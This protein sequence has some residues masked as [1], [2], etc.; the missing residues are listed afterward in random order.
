[1]VVG[2]AVVEGDRERARR[3]RAAALERVDQLVER[4]DAVG[5]LDERH[6]EPERLDRQADV[7]RRVEHL[8]AAVG[9]GVVAQHEAAGPLP[10]EPREREQ[11]GVVQHALQQR[12]DG[13]TVGL[14][15]RPVSHTTL[16]S[17]R[18]SQASARSGARFTTQK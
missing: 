13:A 14:A 5:A 11:A 12:R 17:P 4:D 18:A 15:H 3:E 16:L 9:E 2:V 1:M 7:R 10:R 6:L 8:V